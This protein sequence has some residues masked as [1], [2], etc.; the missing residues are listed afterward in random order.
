MFGKNRIFLLQY[1][2]TI[3]GPLVLFFL[4]AAKLSGHKVIIESHEPPSIY[5]KYLSGLIKSLYLQYEKRVLTWSSH[6]VVHNTFH[7]EEMRSL[8]SKATLSIIPL[9]VY[10]R[11]VKIEDRKR[12]KWGIY[13]QISYKK[14]LDLL[15]EAYQS[16]TAGSLPALKIMGRAAPGNEDYVE[17]LKKSVKSGYSEYIK[18]TGFVAEE[19]KDK[20]FEDL[21]LVI[22]PYRWV[23][24]S[25]ALSEVILYRVPYLAAD[26]PFFKEFHSTFGCGRLFK[27]GSSDDLKEALKLASQDPLSYESE[28]FENIKKAL[29]ME[30]CVKKIEAIL[31]SFTSS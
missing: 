12:D 27:A 13:G 11:E 18:F 29:S 19:D 26:L 24:Q 4:L 15:V 3:T 8:A 6:Y 28:A 14:G 21:G 17:E 31:S 9:P 7:R 25:A 20:A 22:F 2:P 10:N 16:L 1:T 30:S 23:A 5:S